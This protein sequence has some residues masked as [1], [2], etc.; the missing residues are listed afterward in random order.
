RWRTRHDS[1]VWPRPSEGGGHPSWPATAGSNRTT[2]PGTVV[3]PPR[4]QDQRSSHHA[5]DKQWFLVSLVAYDSLPGH[6]RTHGA[7]GLDCIKVANRGRVALI[8]LLLTY[9]P[10][11]QLAAQS[12]AV[13]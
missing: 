5:R 1:K 3:Q 13:A 10:H 9:H 11:L 12:S 2:A 7:R 8:K 4:R 6:Q